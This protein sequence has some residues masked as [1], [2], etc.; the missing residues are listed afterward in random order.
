[1]PDYSLGKIYKIIGKD[2]EGKDGDECYIG[3]TC[4]LHLSNRMSKHRSDYKGW[5]L[6]TR[7][8]VSSYHLFKKY[9]LDNCYIEL[10]ESFPCRS[11]EELNKKEGDIIRQHP[12]NI[13]KLITGRTKHEYHIDNRESILEK[14]RIYCQSH[15]EQIAEKDKNYREKNKE[16]IAERNK[17]YYQKN[18]E[19]IAEKDK[20]RYEKKKEIRSQ[21]FIC[22]CGS[23]IRRGEKSAH[24]KTKKHLFYMERMGMGF[25]R[26]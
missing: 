11:R 6:G 9:G 13:N 10:F 24:S 15:K 5:L 14:K 16:Q 22:E 20:E 1:M 18:K 23:E 21:K 12:N 19:K 8:F 3:S 26:G 17:K 7:D 25:S 2:S 4:Q